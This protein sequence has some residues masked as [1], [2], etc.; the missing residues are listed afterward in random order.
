MPQM[1]FITIAIILMSVGTLAFWQLWTKL[2]LVQ[3]PAA[4]ALIP[5]MFVLFSPATLLVVWWNSPLKGSEWNLPLVLVAFFAALAMFS[6]ALRSFTRRGY[7]IVKI[8]SVFASGVAFV[9]LSLLLS[10]VLVTGL[11]IH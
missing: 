5:G 3:H 9:C 10:V 6:Y 7:Y 11:Q 4:D 1:A 8:L 2:P